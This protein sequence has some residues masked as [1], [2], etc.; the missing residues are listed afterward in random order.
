MSFENRFG[1]DADATAAYVSRLVQTLGDRDPLDVLCGTA[2]ELRRLAASFDVQTL[3]QPEA[4]DKW[5]AL[6]VLQHFADAEFAFGFRFR[7]AM[8]NE[9]PALAGYDQDGW[10]QGLRYG[11]SEPEV[12][13][14]GFDA[15]RAFNILLYRNLSAADLARET[16]HEERGV[17]TVAQML[18]LNAAHDVV[19]LRQLQRIHSTLSLGSS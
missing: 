17:E 5:S 1:A 11:V 16:V 13:I 7:M 19:H 14:A 12:F 8:G 6:Q 15:M 4:D 10:M 18:R 9:R 2:A 3:Y